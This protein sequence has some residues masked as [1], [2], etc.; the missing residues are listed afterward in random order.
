MSAT[1]RD[2]IEALKPLLRER[3][4]MQ[5]CLKHPRHGVEGLTFVELRSE[6]GAMVDLYSGTLGEVMDALRLS[7][8]LSRLM[9]RG[10]GDFKV[11]V[12]HPAHGAAPLVEISTDGD[13][14]LLLTEYSS[15][16]TR[17]AHQRKGGARG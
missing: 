3:G 14:L 2:L 13:S 16:T 5:V 15:G 7:K 8:E 17:T 11:F 12:F 10:G 1:V 9:T 6:R 4:D